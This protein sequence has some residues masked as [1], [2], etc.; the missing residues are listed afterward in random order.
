MITTISETDTGGEP[1]KWGIHIGKNAFFL[2]KWRL[3]TLFLA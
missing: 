2:A 3:H 1:K